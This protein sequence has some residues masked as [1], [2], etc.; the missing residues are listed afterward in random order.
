M[1]LLKTVEPANN[2]VEIMNCPEIK[3]HTP[4]INK[5][6]VVISLLS[7]VM[8]ISLLKYALKISFD[9]QAILLCFFKT[10]IHA[11]LN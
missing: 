3:P 8:L 6:L 11:L 10:T 1:I 5:T 7:S 2:T 9:L 4:A